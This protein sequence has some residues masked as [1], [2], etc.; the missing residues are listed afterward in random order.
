MIVIELLAGVNISRHIMRGHMPGNSLA[1]LEILGKVSE[2]YRT[3]PTSLEKNIKT[4]K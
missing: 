4:L 3:L 2:F 1:K